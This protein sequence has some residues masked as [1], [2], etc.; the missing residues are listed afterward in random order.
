MSSLSS[1]VQDD[2]ES[3]LSD[4]LSTSRGSLGHSWPVSGCSFEESAPRLI[5]TPGYVSPASSMDTNREEET[6]S[7]S[8][9]E[10]M[11]IT[12]AKEFVNKLRLR[13]D[14][15]PER[16]A[17]H[18]LHSPSCRSASCLVFCALCVHAPHGSRCL[19]ADGSPRV[20]QFEASTART[21]CTPIPSH[22]RIAHPCKSFP[23]VSTH[24]Q[25]F[26]VCGAY[27]S[28]HDVG[29]QPCSASLCLHQR[30]SVGIFDC[31]PPT[32]KCRAHACL[33]RSISFGCSPYR[34]RVL[35]SSRASGILCSLFP[36]QN[37]LT[38][39]RHTE[40]VRQRP[41][42]PR[43]LHSLSLRSQVL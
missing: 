3:L 25:I 37:L 10:V 1:S 21:A 18:P 30:A 27:P 40:P 14:V 24:L 38:N 12:K 23:G 29:T 36:C 13:F 28:L 33:Q 6:S 16:Y 34:P 39:G 19:F 2:Q 43:P 8:D 9:H 42:T 22:N 20:I 41:W 17:S 26:A 11:A 15:E 35:A 4:D 31:C 32:P 7:F 5:P